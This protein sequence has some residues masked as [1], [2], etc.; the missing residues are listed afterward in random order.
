MS[1]SVSNNLECPLFVDILV[2]PIQLPCSTLACAQCI[3]H[4]VV[5]NNSLSVL[6]LLLFTASKRLSFDSSGL[7]IECSG[8]MN[9]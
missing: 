7:G 3:V 2:Q 5:G 8:E 9:G 4:Q 6:T 1:V